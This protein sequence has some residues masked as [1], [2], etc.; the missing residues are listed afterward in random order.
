MYR[1]CE[2]YS[3]IAN[4]AVVPSLR[5]LYIALTALCIER[6][7]LPITNNINPE[8][9]IM[10]ATKGT[11]I[12][13]TL[14]ALVLGGGAVLALAGPGGDC[15]GYGGMGY[16]GGGWPM[17]SG[18]MYSGGMY[19]GGMYQGIKGAGGPRQMQ[20]WMLGRLDQQLAL[21]DQQQQQIG[22]LIT[23][24]QQQMPANL[25]QMQ[26]FRSQM[27]N[28]DPAAADYAEQVEILAK[29]QAALMSQRMVER[30]NNHAELYAL[31]TPEQQQSFRQL[32]QQRGERRGGHQRM[33]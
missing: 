9:R 15:Q 31:L 29:Q 28:L 33:W 3:G 5:K 18:G 23:K 21:T 32:Q 7:K 25:A 27:H 4:A 11:K 20:Q 30:A 16:G 6:R 24:H 14:A 22:D 1:C 19:Q 17:H 12:G 2:P 26:Q 13:I 8:D 10:K